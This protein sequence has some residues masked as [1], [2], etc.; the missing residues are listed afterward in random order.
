MYFLAH[1]HGHGKCLQPSQGSQEKAVISS[2]E[3]FLD[4][5]EGYLKGAFR[6]LWSNTL[7]LQIRKEEKQL[8][9]VS[10]GEIKKSS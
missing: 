10:S 5:L 3:I 8:K 4:A 9:E 7:P 2:A 6:I 1:H